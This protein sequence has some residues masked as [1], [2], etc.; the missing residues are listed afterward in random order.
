[1]ER[2]SSRNVSTSPSRPERRQRSELGWYWW[3][4][5]L[6]APRWRL[7]RKGM[8]DHMARPDRRDADTTSPDA[9]MSASVQYLADNMERVPFSSCHVA[10]ATVRTTFAQA[11]RWAR[12]CRRVEPP[13]GLRS[14]DWLRL[15]TLHLYAKRRPHSPWASRT[16]STRRS[17]CFRW[18]TP[19]DDVPPATVAF[20]RT[21]RLE[22]LAGDLP[23]ASPG[24]GRGRCTTRLSINRRRLCRRD[25]R[26]W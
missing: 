14:R 9:R 3:T 12:S 26:I 18:R 13:S 23:S 25:L 10:G 5:L 21:G 11:S 16:A 1:V 7:Y 24:E 20:I 22:P 4:T 6:C 15:T 8:A 2:K 19:W 17:G